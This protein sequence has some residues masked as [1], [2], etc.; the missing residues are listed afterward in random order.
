MDINA[1]LNAYIQG[2]ICFKYFYFN[3]YCL[4]YI[5]SSKEFDR[6]VSA[7]EKLDQLEFDYDGFHRIT[8][9]HIAGL[10]NGKEQILVLQFDGQSTRGLPPGGEWRCFE[11]AKIKNLQITHGEWHTK[12]A[13]QPT[14]CVDNVLKKVK[15]AKG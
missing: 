11:V 13:T 7:I 10:K 15:I 9:P 14:T 8:C 3:L 1:V 6:I 12:P 2:N 4:R 5:M